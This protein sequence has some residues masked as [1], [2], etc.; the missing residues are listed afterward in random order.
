MIFRVLWD[1]ASGR[2]IAFRELVNRHIAGSPESA[3]PE[4][5]AL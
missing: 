5:H 1:E 2:L 3:R 4:I